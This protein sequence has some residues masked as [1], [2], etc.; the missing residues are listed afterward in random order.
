MEK[1]KNK[2]RISQYINNLEQHILNSKDNSKYSMSR[3]DI[4][5]ISLSSVGI[6]L[7]INMLRSQDEIDHVLFYLKLSGSLFILGMIS[8]FISQATSYFANEAEQVATK[9]LI[10]NLKKNT[11]NPI[12]QKKL[13]SKANRLSTCTKWLNALSFFSVIFAIVCLL[14]FILFIFFLSFFNIFFISSFRF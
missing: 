3:F 2:D 5:V 11:E 6:G 4:L 10:Q 7:I 14:F 12:E 8:N 1:I 9:F 13:D